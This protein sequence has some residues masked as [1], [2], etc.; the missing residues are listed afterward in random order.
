MNLPLELTM[1]QQFYLRAYADDAKK[2]TAEQAQQLLLDVMK[3]AMIK[4]NVIRH[5]MRQGMGDL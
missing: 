4:D 1:E 3:Q 5:L 2:L